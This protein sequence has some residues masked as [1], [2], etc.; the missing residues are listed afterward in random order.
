MDVHCIIELK[1]LLKAIKFVINEMLL[2]LLSNSRLYNH[3]SCFFSRPTAVNLSDAATKLKEV[4]LN[5]ATT[6]SEAQSIFQVVNIHCLYI[7]DKG[8][9]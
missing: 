5:A 9:K 3:L 8:Q 6:T 2:Q 4:I 1:S 7:V